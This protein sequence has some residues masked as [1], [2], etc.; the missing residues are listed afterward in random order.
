MKI[1]VIVRTRDE[2][3]RIGPFCESYRW[4][5]QV[6][7]SDGGSLDDTISI[8]SRFPN[9]L[10]RPFGER[11]QL[12]NGLWRN[13]DSGHAN[14]LIACANELAPDWIVY[15]D[16]DCRPNRLLREAGRDL[17]EGT[18]AD[19]ALAVRL[20][21]WGTDQHFPHMAK[22]EPAH[23][24]WE[25]SLWA[26]RGPLD[27]WTVDKPPAYDFRVGDTVLG[28]VHLSHRVL[29]ILPPLCLLHYSWDDPARVDRKV[30]FY[31]ES[32]FIPAMAH[33]LTFAG[34]LNPLPEWAGE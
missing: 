20:Y 23:E 29:D 14:H 6:I 4:A 25:P 34:P 8:A 19:F 2:S 11:V 26:W 32:G 22:P 24:R 3:R 13:N 15:D 30:T 17:L 18:D 21:L 10:L 12:A 5:D 1:V 16:C 7:V 27:F 33:P 28:D 9:V 31:R